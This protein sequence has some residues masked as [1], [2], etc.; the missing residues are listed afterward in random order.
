MT[1]TKITKAEVKQVIK[2]IVRQNP[3]AVNPTAG[4]GTSCVYHIGRG[5]NTRR[6]LIGQ[7]GWELGLP[8]PKSIAGSA[9][10]LAEFGV[11]KGLFTPG[12]ADY[13]TRLQQVAD[14]GIGH[15]PIPWGQIPA[16]V[17]NG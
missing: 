11:W 16:S 9:G 2:R 3:D 4:D 10:S 13:M 17:L 15:P 7:L 1:K 8:T 12:A 6:C 5:R 14:G